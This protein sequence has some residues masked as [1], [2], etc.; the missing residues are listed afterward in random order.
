MLKIKR[1]RRTP[2]Y[3]GQAAGFGWDLGKVAFGHDPEEGKKYNKR[4]KAKEEKN[5]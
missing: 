5:G 4:N 3:Y 1:P 2:Y